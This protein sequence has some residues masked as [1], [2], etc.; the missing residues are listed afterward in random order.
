MSPSDATKLLELPPDA[1]PDQVEARFHELRA[2]LEEKIVKAPT[3]GLKAKYRQSLDEITTAFKTLALAADSSSLPVAQRH[4][5]GGKEQGGSNPSPVGSPLAGTLPTRSAQ[6]PTLHSKPKSGGKEFVV[7]AIIAIMVLAGGGWF[8]MKTRA[9]NAEKARIAAEA[10]AEEERAAAQAKAATAAEARRRET[11]RA[12]VRGRLAELNV[13]FEAIVAA[14]ARVQSSLQSVRSDLEVERRAAPG[15]PSVRNLM[16]QARVAAQEKQLDA[17]R[18]LLREHPARL[19]RSRAESLLTGTDL[20]EGQSALA[21]YAGQLESLERAV[22][23]TAPDLADLDRQTREAAQ[24]LLRWRQ[25]AAGDEMARHIV[26]VFGGSPAGIPPDESA[27]IAWLRNEARRGDAAAMHQVGLLQVAGRLPLPHDPLYGSGERW[28]GQ[29]ADLGHPEANVWMG[30]MLKSSLLS[31]PHFKRAA[32]AGHADGEYEYG[33]AVM[34]GWG[35]NADPA[36]AARWLERA[37]RQGHAAAQYQLGR[38][39]E[40]GRGVPAN[41]TTAYDWMRQAARLGAE[42]ART[43]LRSRGRDW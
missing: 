20:A 36:A 21:A 42:E 11:D 27:A 12:L 7:V 14:D 23:A 1:S 5:A 41:V 31:L 3:P 30:R 40:Q 18:A 22:A 8:V 9:E 38:L 13:R 10:K 29:A 43:Y 33:M 37:A 28:I 15:E 34:M 16:L 4:G 25:L 19:A 2:K 24:V 32:E 35:L 26:R 6:A 17:L 39:Y